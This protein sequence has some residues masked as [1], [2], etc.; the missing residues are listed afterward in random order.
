[1]PNSITFDD[2]VGGV[3]GKSQGITFEDAVRAHEDK[4]TQ[5]QQG[6]QK[7]YE[8]ANSK[9]DPYINPLVVGDA[10]AEMPL[11]RQH[12]LDVAPAE[13]SN[14]KAS[15]KANL[16][17]DP[18]TKRRIIAQELFPDDP[19]A[20]KRVGVID[21]A[22]VYVGDD[23]QLHRVSPK[24][25]SAGAIATA[26]LPEVVGAT[27]GA[28]SGMP[29]AGAA[30]GATAGKAYKQVAA[31]LLLD[32]P[33]T[34]GGNAVEL[35]KEGAL[36]LATGGV[37]KAT[38]KFMDRGKIVDFSPSNL[39]QAEAV[40]AEA[41]AK[42][43]IDLDLAQASG[44]R[45]LI[46]LRAYAAR[47]P[48]QSAD[49]VQAA[50]DASAGQFDKAVKTVLDKIGTA[51]PSEI[52]GAK[53]SNAAELVIAAATARRDAAVKPYYEQAK[54]VVL[55]ADVVDQ[56]AADPLI[57]RAA[58]RVASDPVYQRNLAGLGKD[59][60]GYWQQVKRNL[61]A[62]YSTSATSGDKTA[63]REYADAAAQLN[64]K[65]KAASPEYAQANAFYADQTKKI[66]EPLENSVVGVLAR[67]KSPDKAKA[68]AKIFSDPNI[69]TRQIQDAKSLISG[70][71]PDAWNGLVRSWLGQQLNRASKSTQTGAEVNVPGKFNQAVFGTPDDRQK[72]L[73]MLPTGAVEDMK[74]VLSAAQ[75]LASTPIAGSN[76]MRDTEIKDQLKSTTGVVFNW[77]TS[78]RQAV[79]SAYEQRALE[80][81]TMA[82]TEALLDPAKR[83]QL[84]QV[85]KMA[86]STKQRATLA[87][88]LLGQGTERAVASDDDVLPAQLSQQ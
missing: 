73:T 12:R 36:N 70:Q 52:A 9:P 20:I 71:D 87:A 47:F 22:H 62:A 53:G 40:R 35:A 85:V 23:G 42:T 31:N 79:R 76:T 72:L 2:A 69:S 33:Q 43:G 10:P 58:K 88:I 17:D 46:A 28:A 83:S 11:L 26:N 59:S 50:D 24:S 32:E 81:G 86:P 34:S 49:L 19:N 25:V 29:V 3:S 84:K 4:N 45:K 44:D 78:P 39:K 51:Q 82:I 16:V 48:G 77:L 68:A 74:S 65:L 6:L 54:N 37:A 67:I 56:F 30:L 14:F 66:V 21:G 5:Y 38:T 1:M 57:A 13:K 41:K 8:R 80:Q 75:K 64:E 63:A 60:V 27:I 7:Q 18:E 15:L 61:D 55:G